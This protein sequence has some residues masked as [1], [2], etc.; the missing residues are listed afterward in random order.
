M[1]I[2]IWNCRGAL[3]PSFC[4]IVQDVVRLYS[5]SIMIV[6]ETKVGGSWAKGITDRLPFD[7][8]IHTNAIGYSSGLWVPWDSSQVENSEFLSIK[9]EIH[10]TVKVLSSE[11]SWLLSAGYASSR[12]AKR[13]LIWDNLTTI[14]SLHSL[15]WLLVGDFNKVLLGEDKFGGRPVNI[16]R[17]LKFQD[18]LIPLL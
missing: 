4:S 15:P 6:I 14:S 7:G 10:S 2:V 1:N 17:A 16:H 18:F 5:L 13:C 9:Q 11:F 12:F 3:K 8:A